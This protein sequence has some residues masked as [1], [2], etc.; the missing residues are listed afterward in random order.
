MRVPRYFAVRAEPIHGPRGR[1]FYGIARDGNR[2]R[3]RCY[4]IADDDDRVTK[5]QLDLE[6]KLVANQG[7]HEGNPPE[8][9]SGRHWLGYK[10]LRTRQVDRVTHRLWDLFLK[11]RKDLE[12]LNGIHVPHTQAAKNALR[13]TACRFN[14]FDAALDLGKVAHSR[15]IAYLLNPTERHDQGHLF[16]R[17]FLQQLR[18]PFQLRSDQDIRVSKEHTLRHNGRTYGKIDIW[19]RL[20]DGQIVLLE[21]KIDAGEHPDQIAKYQKWL[22]HQAKP[23]G[24][25]Q[26]GNFPLLTRPRSAPHTSKTT[27]KAGTKGEN[28]PHD[29]C[30]GPSRC[31]ALRAAYL[32]TLRRIFTRFE[33]LDVLFVGF[34]VFTLIFDTSH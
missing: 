14:A 33:K 22:R 10:F 2:D 31:L 29:C 6:K 5:L 30:H 18:V 3:H 12:T 8:K 9:E 28:R 26:G 17:F 1:P 25:P 21:N 13:Q 4:K 32:S 27:T 15:F 7:W 11:Y 24:F 34:I 19:I 23:P 16:L 20:S